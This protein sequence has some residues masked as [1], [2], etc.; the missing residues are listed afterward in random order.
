MSSHLLLLMTSMPKLNHPGTLA[1]FSILHCKNPLS[2]SL[3]YFDSQG[4]SHLRKRCSVF[5]KGGHQFIYHN[6]YLPLSAS[7][8]AL[9]NGFLSQGNLF[10]CRFNFFKQ[11]Q[12]R[13]QQ[14]L[15]Q[16]QRRQCQ[17]RRWCVHCLQLSLDSLP[18][19]SLSLSIS[20]S[21]YTTEWFSFFIIM[22]CISNN[23]N[24]SVE[25]SF[26]VWLIFKT[27][28]KVRLHVGDLHAVGWDE[29]PWALATPAKAIRVKV[30]I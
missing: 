2:L 20:H 13:K 18:I 17:K 26:N 10:L 25:I 19:F 9:N 8:I 30:A 16:Q 14:H 23:R 4:C 15:Q 22:E 28:L 27:K 29:G 21:N 1:Q 7:S 24:L 5:L 3:S 11:F 12:W 6:C